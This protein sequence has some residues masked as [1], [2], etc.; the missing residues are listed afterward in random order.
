MHAS[1]L[2]HAIAQVPAG[3]WGAAVSGGA[4]SIALLSLLR[5]RAL[6]ESGLTLHVVHL[7]H[8]TR[9]AASA[10]DARFV[11]ALAKS[12]GLPSHSA[13][14]DEVEP[15]DAAQK[16]PNIAARF[17]AARFE[18]FRRLAD[19]QQLDGVI[20][21]HHAGD[22]AET[23]MLR[24]LRGSGYSGL[25]GM[26]SDT[27]LYGIRVLRPLLDVAPAMLR[28]YLREIGQPWREDA[29]NRSPTYTRNRVRQVLSDRPELSDDLCKLAVSCRALNGW[30]R[31]AAPILPEKFPAEQL[32]ALP[33]ILA[34]RAAATWLAGIGV[35]ANELTPA[36][37]ERLMQMAS[38]AA[39]SAK[40]QF[41][42]RVV[43]RRR[44]AQIWAETSVAP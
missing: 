13:R 24:L 41:P 23:V 42:G 34:R 4:D 7:D 15:E 39:S 8:Q 43:V 21:A 33:M 38:D 20:L 26:A 40:Q 17:R 18:W 36:V 19:R 25:T 1:R 28:D 22:Q 27:R 44:G 11:Q 16:Y 31:L 30:A 10:G 35:P 2:T 29:T 6:S 12:W 32:A 5:G 9:G 14:R 37:I 3:T